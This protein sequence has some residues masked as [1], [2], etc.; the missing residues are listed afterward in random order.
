MRSR[1]Q[2]VAGRR[3]RIARYGDAVAG[4]IDRDDVALMDYRGNSDLDYQVPLFG[5]APLFLAV[6]VRLVVPVV[7]SLAMLKVLLLFDVI[8]ML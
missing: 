5:Q 2:E 8:V 1:S 4:R 3:H 6:H 7:A